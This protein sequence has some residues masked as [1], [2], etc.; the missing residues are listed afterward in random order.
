VA[1]DSGTR[2]VV[3]VKQDGSALASGWVNTTRARCPATRITMHTQPYP[4]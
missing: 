4:V 3:Q 1:R 2:G